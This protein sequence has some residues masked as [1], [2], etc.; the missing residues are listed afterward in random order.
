MVSNSSNSL[1]SHSSKDTLKDYQQRVIDKLYGADNPHG[2][3]AYHSL[4][5]IHI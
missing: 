1:S 5:L 4:S 3:I 2:L